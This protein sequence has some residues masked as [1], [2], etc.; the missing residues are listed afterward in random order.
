MDINFEEALKL[1]IT[2]NV[3]IKWL[4]IFSKKDDLEYSLTCYNSYVS[5]FDAL[6]MNEFKLLINVVKTFIV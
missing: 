2:K 1:I 6:T 4:K 5:D 3:N